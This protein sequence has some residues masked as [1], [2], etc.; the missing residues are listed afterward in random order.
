MG[1]RLNIGNTVADV[2]LDLVQV[3]TH[4]VITY[5]QKNPISRGPDRHIYMVGVGVFGN[6]GQA[7]LTNMKKCHG[8]VIGQTGKVLIGTLQFNIYKRV[9]FEL[10]HQTRD[11]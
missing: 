8:S 3:K 10:S 6:I 5:L 1:A 9:S 2:D 7:F 4:S 11:T